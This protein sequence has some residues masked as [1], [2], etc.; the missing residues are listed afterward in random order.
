[1]RFNRIFVGFVSFLIF[2]SACHDVSLKIPEGWPEPVISDDKA[3]TSERILLGRHLFFDPVLSADSSISCASCHKPALAFADSVAVSAGV[4]GQLKGFRNTP[5]LF[6]VAWYPYFFAE[7][8]VPDLELLSVA[9]MQTETE[10]DFN[11]GKAVRRLE[12]NSE[13]VRL[14]NEA[15]G[16]NPDT[17]SLTRALAAFQRSLISGNSR[18]D[19]FIR[20]DSAMLSAREIRGMKLFFSDRAGCSDCHSGFLFTDFGF[21]NL[22]HYSNSDPGR[23]RLT[24]AEADRG[25]FK[26]PTLRNIALTAPYLHDG[27]IP[28]LD[29]LMRFYNSGGG[30]GSGKDRRIHPLRLGDGELKDMIAFLKTLTDSSALTDPNYLPLQNNERNK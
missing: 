1:M 14:F 8:G 12:R 4:H 7:G 26:T 15:Y 13:Y 5:T 21:Y 30:K 2:T 17:Y 10:M 3:L 11:T 16:R 27:S 20:G 29:S 25:K 19:Q 6:N 24:S 18:Y 9:P 22:G 28:T 23:F